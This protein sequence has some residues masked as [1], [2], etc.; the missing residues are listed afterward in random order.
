MSCR[1][2]GR[3]LSDFLIEACER[4]LFLTGRD[5]CV[6]RRLA[7][8]GHSPAI[9]SEENFITLALESKIQLYGSGHCCHHI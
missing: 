6:Y 7:A 9:L 5:C 2:S 4:D 3:E 8:C 1:G